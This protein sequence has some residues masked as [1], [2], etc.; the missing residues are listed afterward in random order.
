MLRLSFT[1]M[2]LLSGPRSLRLCEKNCRK[3]GKDFLK[4]ASEGRGIRL[5]ISSSPKALYRF[6]GCRQYLL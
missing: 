6:C 5:S 3:S 4:Q 2:R 1:A